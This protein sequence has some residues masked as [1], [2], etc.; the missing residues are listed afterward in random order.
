[1]TCRYDFLLDELVLDNYIDLETLAIDLLASGLL[2]AKLSEQTKTI[3]C[4]RCCPR[5]VKKERDKIMKYVKNVEEIRQKSR[6]AIGIA[7]SPVAPEVRYGR[8][9]PVSM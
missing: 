4:A 5:C 3:V 1:M 9:D 2:D 8:I 6:A 7:N